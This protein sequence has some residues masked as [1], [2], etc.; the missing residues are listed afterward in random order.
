MEALMF[1][2]KF[3]GADTKCCT[4]N[5]RLLVSSANHVHKSEFNKKWST[6]ISCFYNTLFLGDRYLLP[7]VFGA[8]DSGNVNLLIWLAVDTAMLL[9]TFYGTRW[10]LFKCGLI[11]S[12]L[13]N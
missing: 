12:W 6:F 1:S 11:D 5:Y 9:A 7:V 3:F 13:K 2:R 10:A 4:K 8:T